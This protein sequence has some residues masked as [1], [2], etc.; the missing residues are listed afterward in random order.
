M[1][2]KNINDVVMILLLCVI[3]LTIASELVWASKVNKIRSEAISMG[4]ARY[5]PTNANFE[6]IKP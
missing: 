4:Y 5:N 1:I 3:A 2:M 6:W